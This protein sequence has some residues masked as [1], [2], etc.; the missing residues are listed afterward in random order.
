VSGFH[1]TG[2]LKKQANG[3]TV[4]HRTAHSIIGCQERHEHDKTFY[5]KQV[6]DGDPRSGSSHMNM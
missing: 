4:Q 6:R 1:K 3:E 2:I 5:K